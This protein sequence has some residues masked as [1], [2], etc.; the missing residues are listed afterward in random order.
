MIIR[1]GSTKD[2]GE[3]LEVGK[4]FLGILEFYFNKSLFFV[5]FNTENLHELIKHWTRAISKHFTLLRFFGLNRISFDGDTSTKVVWVTLGLV[6][7]STTNGESFIIISVFHL[8]LTIIFV[9]FHDLF[10]L[11]LG[12]VHLKDL[13]VDTIEVN[14][15]LGRSFLSNYCGWRLFKT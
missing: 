7:M 15:A 11:V 12:L 9:T 1:Y 5:E 4:T 13:L 3:E 10:L 8:L 2:F 6:L 14:L